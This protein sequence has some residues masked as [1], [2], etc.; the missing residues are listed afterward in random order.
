VRAAAVLDLL[1]SRENN[2]SG[3]GTPE[4]LA[5]SPQ[6]ITARAAD[7]CDRGSA[8]DG[9]QHRA[10][11][12]KSLFR[13]LGLT[14]RG[15][16]HGHGETMRARTLF[17]FKGSRD[18][19]SKAVVAQWVFGRRVAT[20]DVFVVASLDADAGVVAPQPALFRSAPDREPLA[21]LRDL[22][23]RIPALLG[24]A[25]HRHLHA[26]FRTRKPAAERCRGGG[27]ERGTRG[28]R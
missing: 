1:S 27:L 24:G 15:G 8:C 23:R 12:S 11:V 28:E 25:D 26:I 16:K 21:V 14:G 6:T 19:P 13:C 10:I 20:V 7:H 17:S 9:P 4:V 22:V 18:S 2:R 5:S 3:E